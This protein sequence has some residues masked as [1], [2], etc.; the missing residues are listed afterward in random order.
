[1]IQIAN[2]DSSQQDHRTLILMRHAKSDWAE[3]SISDHERPLSK[4]GRRDSVR[5]AEWLENIDRIPDLVLCSTSARTRATLE[6]ML[7]YWDESPA[8]IN[9]ENL[10]L[11]SEDEILRE[12]R[13][14]GADADC[15]M[16]LAHNPGIS[17]TASTFADQSIDMPTAAIS[18]FDLQVDSWSQLGDD[19]ERRFSFF[20]R[21]KALTES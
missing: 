10:Y 9:R 13:T 20:M 16:V 3:P 18:I 17:H 12:V 14:E 4:R 1:M 5:M 19:V 11:A 6:L 2:T 21:P 7:D 15:V 8:V